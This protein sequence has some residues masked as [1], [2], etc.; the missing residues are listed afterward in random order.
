MSIITNLFLSCKS[1]KEELFAADA[2]VHQ[3]VC[4]L[5]FPSDLVYQS[6]PDASI[7]LGRKR[8]EPE[9]FE[10][11]AFEVFSGKRRWKL[12][13]RGEIVGQT[14]TQILVY[15]AQT[16]TQTVHFVNSYDGK[17]TR[18]INPAPS[19]LSS[20]NSLDLG[21]A[22]TDEMYIT[23]K[24]LYAQ[25]VENGKIDSTWQIGITAKTWNDNK[26][27]WF[28]PPVKQIVTLEYKLIIYEDKILIINPKQSIDGRHSFQIISLKTGEE[29]SKINTEG[30]FICFNSK[31]FIEK[32]PL[33]IRCFEPFSGKEFWKITG[34]FKN[35]TIYSVGSQLSIVSPNQDKT[36]TVLQFN[37]ETGKALKTFDLPN[38]GSTILNGIFLKNDKQIWLNFSTETYKIPE[39][40]PYNYWVGYDENAKKALWRT[41][42]NNPPTSTLLPFVADKM[43]IDR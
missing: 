21:M 8:I 40:R 41:D 34:Y 22:F 29:L 12:P 4:D 6:S 36:R 15:E 13:F 19:P 10:I 24:S 11:S 42:F 23:T 1:E 39:E 33:F 25:I 7:I 16:Q 37:T 31:H 3:I 26:T 14:S 43:K 30:E 35:A 17:T 28:V 18:K 20:K 38:T 9:I 27:Q 5:A 32:T 2:P